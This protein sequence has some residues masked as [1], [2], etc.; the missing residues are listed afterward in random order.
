[1]KKIVF[2]GILSFLIVFIN[3]TFL[4]AQETS[5]IQKA[6]KSIEQEK[7]LREKIEK[8]RPVPSIKKELPPEI[9]PPPV[10][11][12]KVLIKKIVVSGTTL[13]SEK[14]I[15]DIILCFE[16][17]EITLKGMREIADSITKLY[18]RKGYIT[19]RAYLPP[20]KIKEA[21]LEIKVLEGITGDI[22]IKGNRYFKTSLFK[23]MIILKKGSPLDYNLLR[24]S[25]IKINEQPDRNIIATLN[26]GKDLLSTD[27]HLKVEDRLPMHIGFNWNN[28]SS[29]Y[30]DRDSLQTTLTHNNLLGMGDILE[31]QYQIAQGENY[32]LL[33]LR[34][35]LALNEG[36]KLGFFTSRSKLK[37][38]RECED[39][40]A[41][42]K[43]LLYS[44][45]AIQSLIDGESTTLSLNAGFDYKDN[46]NFQS[47][48]EINRDRLRVAKLEWD[49]DVAD[50]LG[51]TIIINEI[52][53][54]IPNIL[55]GLKKVDERSSRDGSGGKFIKNTLSLIRLQRMPFNSTLLWKNQ[56][57]S[58]PYILP[59]TEQFQIG[60]ISNVR[61]YPPGEASG[62]KGYSMTWEWSFPVYFIPEDI[63]VPLSKIT[64]SNALRTVIFYDWANT[65]LRN[66]QT[67]NQKTRTL[68][69]AGW[70]MRFNPSKGFSI[71]ID[72][73]YPLD[74]T[75]SDN[76]HLHTWCEASISF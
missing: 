40:N 50:A 69:G 13:V 64:L 47:G 53:Y 21:I 71:K 17:K 42:G 33:N 8:E 63:K 23:N 52:D 26:P 3:N 7:I 9:T 4:F 45:Y 73:A 43:N 22:E 76:T 55:A 10:S 19:S 37:L 39:L 16:N 59:A 56:L 34:Y 2:I 18:R 15:N 24:K 5:K 32:R 58:S 61:G 68:R 51:K 30:I 72:F 74:N 65:R 44:I 66:P 36:L 35:L 57:Q 60:G 46:F 48:E 41:R 31:F 67:N 20:Q 12:E 29:R 11:E 28:Y 70:G 38:G 1:M 54:G 75:P 27:I 25:M 6:E 14:E 62:D 49:L